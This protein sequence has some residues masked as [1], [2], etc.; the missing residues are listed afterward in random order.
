V[1]KLFQN[2]E[3]LLFNEYLRPIIGNKQNMSQFKDIYDKSEFNFD[4][5]RAFIIIINVVT[6]Q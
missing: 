1:S 5:M 3:Y 4:D 6:A 2:Y